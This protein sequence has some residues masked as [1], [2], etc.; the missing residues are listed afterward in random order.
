MIAADFALS[1][2]FEGRFSAWILHWKSAA[3][4]IAVQVNR[5]VKHC[6]ETLCGILD[7]LEMFD[8]S[9]RS[10][11]H[12]GHGADVCYHTLSCQTLLV[13]ARSDAWVAREICKCYI[14]YMRSKCMTYSAGTIKNEV[15]LQ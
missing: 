4:Y 11:L 13:R 8:S 10:I 12:W 3:I 14:H 5:V 15:T 9:A 2:V 1:V 7:L 6:G